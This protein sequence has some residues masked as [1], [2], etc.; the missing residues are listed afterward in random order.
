[1]RKAASIEEGKQVRY[2][3]GGRHA[4]MTMIELEGS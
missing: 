2:L 4:V 3:F 1:M